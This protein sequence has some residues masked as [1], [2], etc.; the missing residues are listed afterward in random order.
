MMTMQIE[1]LFFRFTEA[2]ATFLKNTGSKLM[3]IEDAVRK[4]C[5]DGASFCFGGVGA[6]DPFAVVFE[7]VRQ[8][9]RN[10]TNINASG[11]EAI[12]ILIG[13]G[14]IGRVETAYTWIGMF[15][16]GKNYRR[17][18]EEGVPCYI[19]V[20]EYSNFTASLR[21]LAGSM[22]IPFMPTRS[23]LGSDIPKHNDRIK[24]IDDPYGGERLALVPAANPDVAFIHV[25]RADIN[26]NSQIWGLTMNDAELCRAA[27]HTVIT[28]EEIIDTE[29]IRRMPNMTAI[30]SYC[31][32]AVVQIPFCSHPLCLS[33][34]YVCDMPFRREFA[35][36]NETQEGFESWVDEWI[37]KTRDWNGYLD[38]VGADRLSKLKELEHS[39]YQIP[40]VS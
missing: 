21:L 32:D 22:K 7:M 12:C 4:Y 34:Y 6:R 24:I 1:R 29:E 14:C 35:E 33:G 26:G 40:I 23:L 38:K 3:S 30:P 15:S 16:S 8:K 36:M 17:A 25:Q 31:V 19:E 20:E 5:P 37:I 10:L 13:A 18:V 39:T 11:M 28:C 9:K 27:K 2:G